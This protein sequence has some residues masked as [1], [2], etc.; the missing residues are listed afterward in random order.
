MPF[1]LVLSVVV[2][3]EVHANGDGMQHHVVHGPPH[4]QHV[5]VLQVGHQSLVIDRQWHIVGSFGVQGEYGYAEVVLGR[6]FYRRRVSLYHIY[7]VGLFYSHVGG[8]GGAVC[9]RS[10]VDGLAVRD[11]RAH[12][13][14]WG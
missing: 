5:E 11:S 7:P 10:S 1:H 9:G 3:L 13:A 2:R 12:L 4:I 8:G 6:G 14:T